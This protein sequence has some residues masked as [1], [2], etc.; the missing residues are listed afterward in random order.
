LARHA[1]FA[2]AG[3]PTASMSTSLPCDASTGQWLDRGTTPPRRGT[4]VYQKSCD[5]NTIFG[6]R[7]FPNEFF[8]GGLS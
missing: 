5:A 7:R 4:L 8:A 2:D 6:K 3:W 1:R